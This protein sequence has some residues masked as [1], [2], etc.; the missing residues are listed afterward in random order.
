M[1]TPQAYGGIKKKTKSIAEFPKKSAVN[2]GSTASLKR[3][4][5]MSVKR[6]RSSSNGHSFERS[7]VNKSQPSFSLISNCNSKKNPSFCGPKTP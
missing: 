4:S 2:P 7:K 3:G 6:P 1:K 5:K